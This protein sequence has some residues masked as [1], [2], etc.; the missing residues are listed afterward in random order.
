MLYLAFY[1]PWHLAFY[2]LCNLSS[3]LA[4]DQAFYLTLKKLVN[5][6]V[7][8]MI[9]FWHS[10]WPLIWHCIWRI[11]KQ[12]IWH[13]IWHFLWHSLWR[14]PIFPVCRSSSFFKTKA[15]NSCCVWFFWNRPQKIPGW[16]LATPPQVL[17]LLPPA[18][19]SYFCHAKAICMLVEFRIF[20]FKKHQFCWFNPI[21]AGEIQLFA[22]KS[23]W[24]PDFS[25]Q[26][27][28]KQSY[29][30]PSFHRISR[31]RTWP[32]QCRSPLAP[33]AEGAD[34][35]RGP[36]RPGWLAPPEPGIFWLVQTTEMAVYIYLYL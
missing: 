32:R 6:Y 34:W 35:A 21:L 31:L 23:W 28:K 13:S 30:I 10:I 3:Y 8:N 7:N 25:S 17:L 11:F 36:A 14:F 15:T 33:L 4:F 1:L 20:P 24:K 19:S 22:G 18:A 2:M 16:S 29:K 12:F 26:N 9:F 5:L 27:P